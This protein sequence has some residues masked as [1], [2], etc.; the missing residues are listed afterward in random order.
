MARH[1]KQNWGYMISQNRF[2]KSIDAFQEAAKGLLEHL[3]NN[4]LD[5]GAWCGAK[6]AKD[7]GKQYVN[8]L[9]YLSKEGTRLHMNK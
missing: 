2:C 1:M 3:F 7:Q 8:P 5:C 9:G 6:L 4:H